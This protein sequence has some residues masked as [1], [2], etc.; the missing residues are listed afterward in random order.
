M[1]NY[2]CWARQQIFIQEIIMICTVRLRW[3]GVFVN[4][5]ALLL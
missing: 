4:K 3:N 2:D 1:M 5:T